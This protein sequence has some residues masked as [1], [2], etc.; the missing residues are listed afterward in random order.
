M[1]GL[2]PQTVRTGERVETRTT[3]GEVQA[4]LSIRGKRD[5]KPARKLLDP[6]RPVREPSGIAGIRQAV[7]EH[8]KA[9]ECRR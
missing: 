7:P 4:A 2:G 5:A 8:D 9:V 6:H 3:H 1:V